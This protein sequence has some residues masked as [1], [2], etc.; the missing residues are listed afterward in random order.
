MI[1]LYN[2]TL[3]IILLICW[4]PYVLDYYY[5]KEQITDEEKFEEKFNELHRRLFLMELHVKNSGTYSP[6]FS[7]RDPTAQDYKE[8][9]YCVWINVINA[10]IFISSKYLE[11]RWNKLPISVVDKKEL[12]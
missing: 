4:L 1:V 10:T 6:I 7:K 8:D 11:N 12:I 5:K 2:I 9:S 3:I